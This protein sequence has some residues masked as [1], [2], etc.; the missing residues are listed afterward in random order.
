MIRH[1]ASQNAHMKLHTIFLSNNNTIPKPRPHDN[2]ITKT[3]L[4]CC[5]KDRTYHHHKYETQ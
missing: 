1:K 4:I 3:E 2:A 5:H